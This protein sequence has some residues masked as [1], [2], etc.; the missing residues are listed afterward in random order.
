M[1][2]VYKLC[3]CHILHCNHVY[4]TQS[5]SIIQPLT[6]F[7]FTYDECCG[8]WHTI[9]VVVNNYCLS[10]LMQIWLNA[11][12]TVVPYLFVLYFTQVYFGV[13]VR[14]EHLSLKMKTSNQLMKNSNRSAVSLIYGDFPVYHEIVISSSLLHPFFSNISLLNCFI[15]CHVRAIYILLYGIG[16]AHCW[17]PLSVLWVVSILILWSLVGS[18]LKCNH[19]TTSYLYIDIYFYLPKYWI[20]F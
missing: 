9:F 16:F 20:G 17:R 5:F 1:L 11:K 13:S 3:L 2:L 18:C 10:F 4:F 7:F 19:T 15:Y 8:S 14:C 6:V 12:R